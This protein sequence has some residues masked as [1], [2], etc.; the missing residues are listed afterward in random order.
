MIQFWDIKIEY[1]TIT[2]PHETSFKQ[3]WAVKNSYY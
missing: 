1:K 2:S 3:V